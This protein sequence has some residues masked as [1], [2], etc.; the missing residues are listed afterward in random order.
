MTK[1]NGRQWLVVLAFLLVLGGTVFFA[2][3]AIRPAIYWHYH[4]DEPIS[5]W[6]NVEYVA[7]SYHVPPHVL[8]LALGLPHKPPDKRPLRDIAAVQN[9]SMDEIKVI[10]LDAI[11]HARPPY[12]PPPPPPHDE[13]KRP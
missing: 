13:G 5:G 3:R 1:L 4:Q 7:H 12:P 8:Y 6:M 11:V 9:R 2:Q 10:L